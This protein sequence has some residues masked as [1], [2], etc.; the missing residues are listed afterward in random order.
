MT[1]NE[2]HKGGCRC[3]AIRYETCGL[4]A[5]V[6]YC[7]CNDCRISSGSVV[8]VL[9][10][11]Q[12]GGFEIIHGE[13]TY[14]ATA[15]AVKRSFCNTCGTPLF[16]ENQNFPENIYIHIGSFD[17][18]EKLPPDRHTWVSN[19]ISW[20]EIKDDL[21]QYEQLSNAGLPENTPRYKMPDGT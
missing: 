2:L 13:P 18:P 7:H 14:F 12:R 15:P 17:E 3:G 5:M 16:Y 19:R 6:A 20:H 8:S 1:K 9:A 10:G 4:P 21:T 11:F